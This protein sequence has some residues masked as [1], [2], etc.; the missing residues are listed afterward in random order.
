MTTNRMEQRER[1]GREVGELQGRDGI[2]SGLGQGR[3]GQGL[4]GYAM[5][6][7]GRRERS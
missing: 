4:V 7:E 6:V 2:G 5:G 1:G 3:G